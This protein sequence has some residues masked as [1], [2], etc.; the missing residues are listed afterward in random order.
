MHDKVKETTNRRRICSA[1]SC[2]ES[3]DGTIAIEKEKVL[4]RW[5]E[6]IQELFEDN[7]E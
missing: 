6:Y 7:R 2:V 5:E 1:A 3:K 4:E